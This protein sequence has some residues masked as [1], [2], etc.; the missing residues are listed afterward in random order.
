MP[1][2]MDTTGEEWSR[3]EEGEEEEEEGEDEEE[4]GEDEEEEEEGEEEV[5]EEEGDL[6]RLSEA[7]IVCLCLY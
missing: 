2:V 5:D 4:E 1:V 3:E 7:V 6:G